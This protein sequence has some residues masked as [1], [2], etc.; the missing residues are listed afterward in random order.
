[1]TSVIRPVKGTRDFYPDNMAFR[2]WLY[3]QART[4][5]ELFGFQEYE[6]PILE[7]I[8]LYAAKSGEEL[9][10]RQ[11]YVFQ[12]RGE[13]WITL[14]PELTPTLARMVA[15]RQSQL[16]FP[17]RW[18]S[19][20]PFW[21][22]ERPQKGRTREFFQWNID[23]IG[24]PSAAADAELIAIAATFLRQIGLSASEAKILINHRQLMAQELSVLDISPELNTEIFGLIDRK[25]KLPADA[26]GT[27]AL[28]AGLS[29]AQVSGIQDLLADDTLWQKSPDLTETFS[30]LDEYGIRDYVQFSPSIIRG[31]QYYTG[32]VF[33]AWDTSSRF[34]ALFGGGRYDNLVG[35]VGGQPVG[36]VGFAVGDLVV[37]L[38]LEALNKTPNLR[39]SP[40][41]VFMTLFDEASKQLTTAMANELRNAGIPCI[42]QLA[43]EKLGKQFKFADRIGM[44]YAI[45][46]GPDEVT[47][48][49]VTVKDLRS[50][51]Q[52]SIPRSELT[53]KLKDLLTG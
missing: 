1:M 45:V 12:D 19:F 43:T 44:D 17:L 27:Q 20:G 29:S 46:C 8:D 28:E 36:G 18:W 32:A 42:L 24:D 3:Q 40:A 6:G 13:D 53:A 16:V 34:R 14:R 48:R 23:L 21:R 49:S 10:K 37:G 4:V 33:E 30:L 51:E 15:Q 50:G 5:S 38:L 26:W 22:Y 11:S 25:D 41:R 9:V 7:T 35:D 47:S 39:T 52:H 2:T 31:L